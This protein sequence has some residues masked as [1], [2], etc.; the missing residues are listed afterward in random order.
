MNKKKGHLPQ[1]EKRLPTYG[2]AHPPTT[3]DAVHPTPTHRLNLYYIQQYSSAAVRTAEHL[4]PKKNKLVLYPLY[5]ILKNNIIT[6]FVPL[7]NGF[8]SFRA[9][10]D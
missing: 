5:V 8:Y 10:T 1:D 6:D 4:H 3:D 7:R 2:T 9:Q